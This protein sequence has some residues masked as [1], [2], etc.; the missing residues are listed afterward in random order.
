MTWSVQNDPFFW[1]CVQ[2]GSKHAHHFY[3][4]GLR[5]T[6]LPPE[7]DSGHPPVFG[8]YLAFIW[9]VFGKTLQVSHWAMLPFI[10]LNTGL[11]FRLGQLLGG[12]RFG[13]WLMPLALLDPVMAGQHILVGPDTVLVAFFL[14]ATLGILEQRKILLLLGV[15]GLCAVSMRGMMTAGAIFLW[16]MLISGKSWATWLKQKDVAA[17][18]SAFVRLSI[19]FLPGFLF[20]GWFLW[21]HW[22]TTGW[23]GY[24]PGSPW[25]PTFERADTGQLLRNIL[26]VGWRWLDFGRVFVWLA[27]FGLIGKSVLSKQNPLRDDIVFRNLLLLLLCLAVF[28]TP[29]SVLLKNV[30]A[31]RYVLPGFLALNLLTFR[32]LATASMSARSRVIITVFLVIALA[33]GNRWIYPRGIA[34]GWDAT[35]A[36]LPYHDLRKEALEYLDRENIDFQTVGSAFPNLNTGENLLLNGDERRFAYKDY[37]TNRFVF[38]SNIFND[39]SEADYVI[40]NKDWVMM[41][42]FEKAGVWIEIYR[43]K[44]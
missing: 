36:H 9:S 31:H 30:S 15:F 19:P 23:I 39:F 33:F 38:A 17:L 20:A 13:Y 32:L 29:S 27:L 4:N 26:I 44:E 41:K 3:L 10:L 6:P 14:L 7:I 37:A 5:W 22:S 18:F 12:I 25:A 16:Q 42:R 40:L 28:L 24:H 2:L 8:W 1:D 21:W 43:R 34:M 11:L 35:L